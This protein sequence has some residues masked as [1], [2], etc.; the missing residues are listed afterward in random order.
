MKK[1]FMLVEFQVLKKVL[2]NVFVKLLTPETLMTTV[3]VKKLI[4]A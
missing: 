4:L 2:M 1:D 3:V